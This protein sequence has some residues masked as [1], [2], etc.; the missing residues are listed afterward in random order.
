MNIA[1]AV[2]AAAAQQV[3]AAGSGASANS[4][5]SILAAGESDENAQ[6]LAV[7]MKMMGVEKTMAPISCADVASGLSP[8]RGGGQQKKPPSGGAGVPSTIAEQQNSDALN[9]VPPLKDPAITQALHS[10]RCSVVAD[11]NSQ[12][13]LLCAAIGVK[14]AS[15][16]GFPDA[17]INAV[18]LFDGPQA[19]NTI[20]RN[21]TTSTNEAVQAKQMV[22]NNLTSN[23]PLPGL[24][25]DAAALPEAKAYL[26]DWQRFEAEKSL[27]AYPAREYARL[28]DQDSSKEMVNALTA[29]NT[30]SYSNIF[31]KYPEAQA[32]LS[33]GK[34]VSALTMMEME[35]EKRVGNTK[36]YE[37]MNTSDETI[38]AKERTMMQAYSMRIQ[39]QQYVATLQ[40]NVLLGKILGDMSD[41][42][43]RTKLMDA[44]AQ[45]E[46]KAR[47]S[48]ANSQA[49]SSSANKSANSSSTAP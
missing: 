48:V 11:P 42:V 29:L 3:S 24:S 21:L 18:T 36:W 49:A 45:L 20:T 7:A 13:G 39:M 31:T 37:D 19:S 43:F 15:T 16:L 44:T 33:A 2:T 5:G 9:P 47:T 6:S 4:A 34:G 28:T 8:R 27:A 30:G 10:Q 14:P 12:R 32:A 41:S 38:L 46:L 26:G 23:N 40:Q 22:L 17:D 1:A 35:V 25:K